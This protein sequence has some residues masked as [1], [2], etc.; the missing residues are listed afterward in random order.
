MG[1][2]KGPMRQ[3]KPKLK[4]DFELEPNTGH[5]ENDQDSNPNRD[6]G[7][8]AEEPDKEPEKPPPNKQKRPNPKAAVNDEDGRQRG[9]GKGPEL[10]RKLSRER[11]PKLEK[12]K[13][14]LPKLKGKDPKSKAAK[15]TRPKEVLPTYLTNFEQ[16]L[17]KSLVGDKRVMYLLRCKVHYANARAVEA[18]RAAGAQMLTIGHT[19]L[20]QPPKFFGD[21]TLREITE[22]ITTMEVHFEATNLP[23]SDWAQSAGTCFNKNSLSGYVRWKQAKEEARTMLTWKD[24]VKHLQEEFMTKDLQWLALVQLT[25]VKLAAKLIDDRQKFETL[26]ACYHKAQYYATNKPS[27]ITNKVDNVQQ[28]EVQVKQPKPSWRGKGPAKETKE[29]MEPW[30]TWGSNKRPAGGLDSHQGPPHRKQRE[31]WKEGLSQTSK[32]KWKPT[33]RKE[34]KTKAPL[35]CFLCGKIGHIKKDC[36]QSKEGQPGGSSGKVKFNSVQVESKVQDSNPDELVSKLACESSQVDRKPSGNEPLIIDLPNEDA[37]FVPWNLCLGIC[38]EAR[39]FKCREDLYVLDSTRI[40][41]VLLMDFNKRYHVIL[42]PKE[43]FLAILVGRGEFLKILGTHEW[44][45][46]SQMGGSTL[47]MIELETKLI[48]SKQLLKDMQGG[49]ETW[50]ICYK[51]IKVG[52]SKE[53]HEAK[54]AKAKPK[55]EAKVGVNPRGEGK[56]ILEQFQDV[57]SDP[58]PLGIRWIA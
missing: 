19:T 48:T 8:S 49:F 11:K 13:E 6:K 38:A 32:S 58:L 39:E 21:Y 18:E 20:L 41:S 12:C 2:N 34:A 33:P 51:S 52:P 1:P 17:A 56:A 46:H 40:E 30:K 29:G 28:W 35:A 44:S 10:E 9:K 22:W 7:N 53:E 47:K 23:Q 27:L 45:R 54:K 16:E 26:T 24:L 3:H 14:R 4:Q 43:D 15:A 5:E 37:G 42:H 50:Q 36:P 55:K 57:L 31:E 25:Q